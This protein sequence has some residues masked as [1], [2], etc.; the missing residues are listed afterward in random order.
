MNARG[1]QSR[2]PGLVWQLNQDP[3]SGHE[4]MSMPWCFNTLMHN[5]GLLF[6]EAVWPRRFLFPT[7]ILTLMGFPVVPFVS[8]DGPPLCSFNLPRTRHPQRVAE[9]A[10]NSMN[11]LVITAV[12]LHSL[13]C[14][15]YR[16]LPDLISNIAL[17]K[18]FVRGEA[19]RSRIQILDNVDANK[20][21]RITAKRPDAA[22]AFAVRSESR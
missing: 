4:M 20:R 2:Y 13:V 1:Y 19:V 5:A 16:K 6:T 17:A 10:G 15:K 14:Y 8:H 18:Q 22:K 9:Q 21:R 11:V 7:E 3:L 12:Q